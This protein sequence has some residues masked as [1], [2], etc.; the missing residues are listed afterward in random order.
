M[1]KVLYFEGGTSDSTFFLRKLYPSGAIK[2]TFIYKNGELNGKAIGFY[3]DGGVG[4]LVHYAEGMRHGLEMRWTEE[5][6]LRSRFLFDEE[7]RIEGSFFYENGQPTADL[8]F[9][10]LGRVK[11][12]VYYHR[13]GNL[14]SKGAFHENNEKIKQGIWELYHENGVL[15]EK[16]LYE[17]GVRRGDWYYYD[18]L[19]NQTMVVPYH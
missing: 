6:F 2:S 12:G 11:E 10:S 5:G 1:E 19:G 18:S 9:D 15:K 4:L 7:K 8:V 16:G 13:N 3:E 14:R 17:N